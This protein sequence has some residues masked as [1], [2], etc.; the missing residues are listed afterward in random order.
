MTTIKVPLK[1][2]GTRKKSGRLLW[3][4]IEGLKNHYGFLPHNLRLEGYKKTSES[5]VLKYEV[6]GDF[7]GGNKDLHRSPYKD[8]SYTSFK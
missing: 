3:D 1:E 6:G 4:V 7:I 5:L 2:N 8:R